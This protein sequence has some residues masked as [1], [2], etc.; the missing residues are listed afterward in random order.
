MLEGHCIIRRSGGLL[1]LAG[2]LKQGNESVG[3]WHS[4]MTRINNNYLRIFY[5]MEEIQQGQ[6]QRT[7]GLCTV[8]LGV[9][10]IN[11]LNGYWVVVGREEMLGSVKYTRV[12]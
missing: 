12:N 4:E 1:T 11:E 5:E 6:P 3:S 10:P 7:E 8:S 2:E 9:P